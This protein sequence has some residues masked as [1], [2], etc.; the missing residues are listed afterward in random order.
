MTLLTHRSTH[1]RWRPETELT[2]GLLEKPREAERS[3]DAQ[4]APG[5]QLN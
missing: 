5:W 4:G 1:S 2:E 3:L